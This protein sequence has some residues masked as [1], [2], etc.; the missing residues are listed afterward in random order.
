MKWQKLKQAVA[1]SQ[2]KVVLRAVYENGISVLLLIL[3][4]IA[5]LLPALHLNFHIVLKTR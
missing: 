4:Y 2:N 3:M 5:I 1:V